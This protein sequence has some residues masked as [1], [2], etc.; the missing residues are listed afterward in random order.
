MTPP[1]TNTTATNT[2]ND[3]DDD[4]DDIEFVAATSTP[5]SSA[6]S[7]P[8]RRSSRIRNRPTP[9]AIPSSASVPGIDDAG[10]DSDGTPHRLEQIDCIS[11]ADFGLDP[12]HPS[13]RLRVWVHPVAMALI[14]LHAHMSRTEVIGLLG[15]TIIQTGSSDE[16]LTHVI[17]AEAFPAQGIADRVLAKSGRN[18]FSEVELDPE[19]S[20]EVISRINQKNLQVV[21]WYHSHPD[22]AFSVEPSRVDIENQANYQHL[23]FKDCPFIAA[24]IAPYNE[25]LPDHNPQFQFF[26]VYQQDV[27]IK[28]PYKVR[29]LDFSS[30]SSLLYDR[31]DI[32]TLDVEQVINALRGYRFADAAKFPMEDFVAECFTLI[33]HYWCFPKR[34]RLDQEWKDGIKMFQKLRSCLK[35]VIDDMTHTAVEAGPQ[36]NGNENGHGEE[37]HQ[38]QEPQQ[39]PQ[40]EPQQK[41][42]QVPLQEPQQKLSQEPLQE[43][44]QEPMQEPPH[45]QQQEPPHEQQQEQQQQ[46]QQQHEEQ[47]KTGQLQ[48]QQQQDRPTSVCSVIRNREDYME[49]IDL[50]MDEVEQ[51]WIESG[52]K[53]DE[54]RERNRLAA[55]K[56]K[57]QRRR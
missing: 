8:P 45:K 22:K 2:P 46:Q 48:L 5:P 47:L 28:L 25:D 37:V 7:A 34:Y 18:A 57:R 10:D 21:G 31:H 1:T 56:K 52:Q 19:S 35:S 15:G 17:V 38:S 20:V 13:S 9:F 40:T 14:S 24:I 39:E 3:D 41:M 29:C 26:H 43:P 4:D 42:P 51:R 32:G 50:V 36:T 27:P 11:P 16:S 54:K 12:S 30:S 49:G 44:L 55:K 6:N 33:S 23:L 53:D